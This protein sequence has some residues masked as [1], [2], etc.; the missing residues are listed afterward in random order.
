MFNSNIWPNWGPFRDIRLPNVSDLESDLSR[1]LKV[2]R[3]S[4]IGLAVY[5]F[6]LM[7]KSNIGPNLAPLGDIRL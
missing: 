6:L 7:V 2:K 3:Y 1:S 5:G 4:E